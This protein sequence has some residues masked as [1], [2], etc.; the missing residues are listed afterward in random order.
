MEKEEI[1]RDGGKPQKNSGRGKIQKADAILEPFCYDIKEYKKSFSVSREVWA[2]ICSDAYQS[3]NGLFGRYEPAIK[4]VLGE[5]NSKIR[6][7]LIEDD[8]MKEMREAWV[9][10]YG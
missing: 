6:L 2:K 9:E 4:I 7:W 1:R 8:M 3:G 10:K 5:P